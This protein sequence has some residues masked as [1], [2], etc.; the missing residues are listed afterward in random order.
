MADDAYAEACRKFEQLQIEQKAAKPITLIN[1]TPTATD[2]FVMAIKTAIL[3]A[4]AP[5]AARLAA[6]EQR[7]AAFVPPKAQGFVIDV[8]DVASV[9]RFARALRA[10]GATPKAVRDALAALGSVQAPATAVV[11]GV[12][13]E[14][15]AIVH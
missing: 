13:A 10:D 12:P 1:E 11:P 15:P 2:A 3:N 9:D 6:L 8:N 7:A 14:P 4:T 5:L